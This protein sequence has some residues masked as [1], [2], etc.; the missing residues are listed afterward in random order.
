MDQEPLTTR[1]RK[2]F[3]YQDSDSDSLPSAIDEEGERAENPP[4]L[5]QLIG[6]L[7]EEAFLLLSF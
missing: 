2:P 4:L 7:S 5:S 6:T 1:L 3:A